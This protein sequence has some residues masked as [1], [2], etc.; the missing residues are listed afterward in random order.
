MSR[1]HSTESVFRA[2]AHP[3][4]RRIIELL[5]A[6]D[7]KAGEFAAEPGVTRAA[8]SQHLAVLLATGVVSF[9]RKGT[10][11]VYRL[12]RAALAGVGE[13]VAKHRSRR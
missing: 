6:G 11:L 12:N 3:R 2:L 13:W 4:R 10:S 9:Q 5:H 1:P 8:M 7:L